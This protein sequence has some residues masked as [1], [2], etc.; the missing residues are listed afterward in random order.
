[1]L[2]YTTGSIGSGGSDNPISWTTAISVQNENAHY[3]YMMA[4]THTI[5]AGP[6]LGYD[7]SWS[8]ITGGPSVGNTGG[9]SAHTHGINQDTFIPKYQKIIAAIKDA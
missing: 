5:A 1:M 9:G 8:N 3:H 2:V 7:D 4:H 6:T